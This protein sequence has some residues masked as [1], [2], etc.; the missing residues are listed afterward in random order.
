MSK[1]EER[2]QA[3]QAQVG[4]LQQTVLKLQEQLQEENAEMK[5]LQDDL[6]K[7]IQDRCDSSKS[8]L[9]CLAR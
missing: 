2:L 1:L 5:E 3:E 9:G 6:G 8:L 4:E 7:T